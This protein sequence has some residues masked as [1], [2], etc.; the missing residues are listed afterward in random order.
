MITENLSTLKIHKLSQAQYDRELEAGRIDETAL[1]LTP[2]N[3]DGA[4]LATGS[5][6]GTG[7]G[8]K[9]LTFTQTPKIVF[10]SG[11]V[12][13]NFTTAM[14]YVWGG[15][16]L[17]TYCSTAGVNHTNNNVTISG[18]TMSW[19]NSLADTN[20]KYLLALNYSGY[21][22]QYLVIY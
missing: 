18:N 14:P 10:I 15:S 6:V 4:N 8:T 16:G 2:D 19:S 9:S 11:G 5:Y 3:M 13:S 1:Y 21:T 17:T 12:D 20:S 7:S 22:Y